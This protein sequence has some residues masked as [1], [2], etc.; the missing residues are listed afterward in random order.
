MPLNGLERKYL[1]MNKYLKGKVLWFDLR[2]GNG[3]IVSEGL[4]YYTD[5]SAIDRRGSLKS[6]QLVTF[7][8]NE[9]IHDCLCAKNVK[10]FI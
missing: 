10:E 5:I 3:I 8:I 1:V 6:G 7:Q 4:R 2:D 9:D